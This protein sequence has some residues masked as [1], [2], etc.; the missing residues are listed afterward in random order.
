[1][2]AQNLVYTNKTTVSAA[3]ASADS[4]TLTCGFRPRHIRVYNAT[5]AATY[6]WFE[7][8]ANPSATQ[9]V[10]AGDLTVLTTTGIT[11]SDTG[12]TVGTGIVNAEND[13]IHSVAW[14]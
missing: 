11:V 8:M 1:M 2:Y 13:V 10:T 3:Q 12:F 9:R 14:R 6:E 4:Y 7:G 5:T